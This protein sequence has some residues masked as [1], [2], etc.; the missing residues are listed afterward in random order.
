MITHRPSLHASKWRSSSA[1]NSIISFVPYLLGQTNSLFLFTVNGKPYEHSQIFQNHSNDSVEIKKTIR[2][3]FTTLNQFRCISLLIETAN[4]IYLFI[5]FCLQIEREVDR[6]YKSIVVVGDKKY[7]STEWC[8]NFPMIN[9]I[10]HQD[11]IDLF[12]L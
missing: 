1:F 9:D 2:F 8:V 7:S 5:L 4:F 12:S 11:P 10:D 3:K 6:W